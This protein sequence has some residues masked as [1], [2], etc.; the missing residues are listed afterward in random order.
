MHNHAQLFFAFLVD[1]GFHHVDQAGLEFLT[2]GDPP[3]LVSQSAG[4]TGVSHCTWL[5]LIFLTAAYYFN[6]LPLKK[7]KRQCFTILVRLVLNS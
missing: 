3:A 4:I 1:T 5:D 6:N 7:K 2:A